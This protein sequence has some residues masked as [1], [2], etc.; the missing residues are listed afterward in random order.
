M[1]A[2]HDLIDRWFRFDCETSSKTGWVEA[3]LFSDDRLLCVCVCELESFLTAWHLPTGNF[4][5]SEAPLL[6]NPPPASETHSGKKRRRT[7]GDAAGGRAKLTLKDKFDIL[8]FWD[9]FPDQQN[10]ALIGRKYNVSRQSIRK[11]ISNRELVLQD[12]HNGVPH[13]AKRSRVLAPDMA[14]LDEHIVEYINSLVS[15]SSPVKKNNIPTTA[16][17][18]KAKA[19]EVAATLNIKVNKVVQYMQTYLY[20]HA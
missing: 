8:T 14:Q 10:Y 3:R 13:D 6:T 18:I 19:T 20:F 17:N 16:E 12:Y 9:Q 4:T 5:M 7:E 1:I 11:V 15:T 2:R